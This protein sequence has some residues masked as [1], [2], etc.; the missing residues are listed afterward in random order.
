M[1]KTAPRRPQEGPETDP[2]RPKMAPRRL[3]EGPRWPQEGS[4]RGPTG[5]PRGISEPTWLREPSRKLPGPS[6]TPPG[7]DF[8]TNL[9]PKADPRRP[10]CRQS[11]SNYCHA[12]C[13][14]LRC[15][16]GTAAGFAAGRWITQQAAKTASRQPKMAPRLPK[17]APTGLP[18]CP[19][20]VPR[21]LQECSWSSLGSSRGPQDPQDG[22]RGPQ[23]DPK[24]LPGCPQQAPRCPQRGGLHITA[25]KQR[26]P[27]R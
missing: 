6:Q 5:V 2:R 19:R 16:V 10:H 8:G 3:Q 11:R 22:P 7:S 13:F 12:S 17:L 18:N 23:D 1:L 27:K 24:G 25:P 15:D 14:L 4:K 20:C 9:V 21:C 26:C